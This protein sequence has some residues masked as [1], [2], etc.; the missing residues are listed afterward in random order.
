MDAH[1]TSIVNLSCN[2]SRE[3]NETLP[4][5]SHRLLSASPWPESLTG[6]NVS[7]PRLVGLSGS[8]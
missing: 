4:S 3:T 8:L 2:Q 6:T 7:L 5:D 1:V